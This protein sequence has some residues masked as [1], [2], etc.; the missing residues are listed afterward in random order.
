MSPDRTRFLDAAAR[1]GRRLAATRS[2]P[3]GDVTGSTG[4]WSRAAWWA[5]GHGLSAM[6]SLVYDGTTGIDLFLAR[7]E[8]TAGRHRLPAEGMELDY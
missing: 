5:V 7:L 6:G 1:I 4:R 2:G 3:T 8:C